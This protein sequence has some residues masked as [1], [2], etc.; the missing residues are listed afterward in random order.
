MPVSGD[1]VDAGYIEALVGDSRYIARGQLFQ[2]ISF[3]IFEHYPTLKDD[4]YM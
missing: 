1:D 4:K 3:A 2:I